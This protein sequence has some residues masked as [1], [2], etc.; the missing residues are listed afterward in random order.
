MSTCMDNKLVEAPNNASILY[1][2][3]NVGVWCRFNRNILFVRLRK[4][5]FS[6]NKISNDVYEQYKQT[7]GDLLSDE[8][9]TKI[10]LY[11]CA[12]WKMYII[13]VV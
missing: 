2:E 3:K 8:T 6:I 9:E 4:I 5:Y 11:T 13:Y 12:H 10:S 7:N 1:T